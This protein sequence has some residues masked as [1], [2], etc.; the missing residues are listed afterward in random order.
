MFDKTII[1]GLPIS[2]NTVEAYY[3]VPSQFVSLSPEEQVTLSTAQTNTL[4]NA[5][6]ATAQRAA[7]E[8]AK[9]A[10]ESARD[11][12]VSSANSATA[13]ASTA[14]NAVSTASTAASTATTQASN[15][16]TYA[17]NAANSALSASGSAI[18]A[19]SSASAAQTIK[20]DIETIVATIPDGTI[21]DST[22][23]LTDV[24]SSTKVLTELSNKVS[25]TGGTASGITLN[26]GYIEEVFDISG[27]TPAL[28]PNQGSIQTWVL[29]G[30]STP[31]LGTWASGQSIVLGVTASSYSITWP[32]I[33]W[34]KV[35]G[36]G[37]APTLKNTGVNW[38]VLWK[39]GTTVTA[40]FLGT[41]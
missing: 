22:T 32:T 30:N 11:T 29:S 23:S 15:A 3:E 34:T 2:S 12:A 14:T 31:T 10:A 7:A 35:G 16:N 4:A 27:I 19:A 36:A 8:A 41:A 1:F 5:N 28:T 26:D 37:S 20:T 25:S 33:V 21:N 39:V 38:I 24:W 6:N 40:S 13:A 17:T 18:A 9:L